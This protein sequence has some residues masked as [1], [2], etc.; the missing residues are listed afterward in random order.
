MGE[1]PS[2]EKN[3]N[4]FYHGG[5]GLSMTFGKIFD[6]FLQMDIKGIKIFF[7]QFSPFCKI[8]LINRIVYDIIRFG[9]KGYGAKT[10]SLQK[11]LC[12]KM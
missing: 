5:G 4:P 7:R 10:P 3:C 9:A 12:S 11:T 6:R 2:F 8:L 1:T